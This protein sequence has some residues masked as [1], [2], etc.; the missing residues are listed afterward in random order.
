MKRLALVLLV[1]LAA[2]PAAGAPPPR[3]PAPTGRTPPSVD[4]GAPNTWVT[5]APN[6]STFSFDANFSFAASEPSTFECSLDG[7]AFTACGSTSS[8]ATTRTSPRGR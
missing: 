6:N 7:G 5:S 4:R 2:V 8:S 3:P 1:T